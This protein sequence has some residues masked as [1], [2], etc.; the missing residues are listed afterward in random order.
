[1]TDLTLPDLTSP[2]ATL[3]DLSLPA[4]HVLMALAEHDQ[5]G[6]AILKDIEQS[7]DGAIVLSAGS[8]YGLIKRLENQ[9]LIEESDERPPARWDDERR[10]Y[11]RLTT[12]GRKAALAKVD[13]LRWTL[14]V[15]RGRG[16]ESSEA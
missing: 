15:A 6:W 4:L 3:P 14:A 9:G 16:L 2:E 12:L 13:S 11:Y 7:T 8:L 1:M 10:R 5:H